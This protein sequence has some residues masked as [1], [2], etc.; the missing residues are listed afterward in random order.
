MY[1]FKLCVGAAVALLGIDTPSQVRKSGPEP[2]T[3]SL[4]ETIMSCPHSI[5][6][7]GESPLGALAPIVPSYN[8]NMGPPM[9]ASFSPVAS[10]SIKVLSR[11]LALNR[12]ELG[13]T[14]EFH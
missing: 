5:W 14:A 3:P 1:G 12:I 11:R 6:P 8:K 13:N 4:L 9:E 10:A 2:G 7:D